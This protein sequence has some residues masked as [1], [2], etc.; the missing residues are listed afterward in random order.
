MK[1][2]K[3]KLKQ[4]IKEEISRLPDEKLKS[5]N[6]KHIKEWDTDPE[7][8]E[9]QELDELYSEIEDLTSK[10]LTKSDLDEM[11]EL[12]NFLDDLLGISRANNPYPTRRR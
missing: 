11:R 12:Y 4:I 1:I 10:I 9:K 2:T 7:E 5:G 8:E 6:K 3:N